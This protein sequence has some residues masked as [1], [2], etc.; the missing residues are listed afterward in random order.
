[1]YTPKKKKQKEKYSENIQNKK[2]HLSGLKKVNE[3]WN[4]KA[5]KVTKNG[6]QSTFD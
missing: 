6:Q 3:G 4:T 5:N 2:I 1:M